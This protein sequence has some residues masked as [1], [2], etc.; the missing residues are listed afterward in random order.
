LAKFKPPANFSAH[1]PHIWQSLPISP[2]VDQPPA[3][4]RTSESRQGFHFIRA[5]PVSRF[6]LDE[7]DISTPDADNVPGS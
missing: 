5:R 7:H 4:R 2:A 3:I 1:F 6:H